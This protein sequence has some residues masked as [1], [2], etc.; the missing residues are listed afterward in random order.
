MNNVSSQLINLHCISKIMGFDFDD[1]NY[2]VTA[3]NCATYYFD[4]V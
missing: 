2:T 1:K 3:I 4:Y